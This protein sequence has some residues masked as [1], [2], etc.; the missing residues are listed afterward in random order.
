MVNVEA[1]LEQIRRDNK[2]LQELFAASER[3]RQSM[4]TKLEMFMKKIASKFP[5]PE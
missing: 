4:E 2:A 5:D 1:S 3:R